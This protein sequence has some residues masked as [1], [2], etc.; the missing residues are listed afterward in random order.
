L[1]A[2]EHPLLSAIF[3][4]NTPKA[5]KLISKLTGKKLGEIRE[6]INHFNP[7]MLAAHFGN[8]EV[9][10]ELINKGMPLNKRR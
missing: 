5:L 10:A 4:K 6:S 9:V 1:D 8:E 3:E 7:L 2:R